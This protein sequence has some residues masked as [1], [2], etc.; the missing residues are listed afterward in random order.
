MKR[1]VPGS[2]RSGQTSHR[3]SAPARRNFEAALADIAPALIAPISS[4]E[5]VADVI[6]EAARSLVGCPMGFVAS[7]DTT[8]GA[9]VAHTL[10][11]R[12]TDC[13]LSGHDGGIA[14]RPDAEGRF[15]GLLGLALNQGKGFFTNA[16]ATH[17]A[18]VGLPAGHQPL[19]NLLAVPA[20][21]A[22]RAAGLI[23]LANHPEGFSEDDVTLV[24]RLARTYGLTLRRMQLDEAIRRSER[25]FRAL[26]EGS[27]DVML[28]LDGEGRA[29]YL[30]PAVRRVLGY[31]PEKLL[32]RPLLD[33]V[34]GEGATSLRRDIEFVMAGRP[35]DGARYRMR[36]ADGSFVDVELNAAPI[37]EGGRVVYVNGVLRDISERLRIEEQMRHMQKMEAIGTLAG[38]VAHDFNNLLTAIIGYASD[39]KDEAPP[40]DMVYEAA[41]VIEDAGRQ[42]AELTG[43]LLGFARKGKVRDEAVDVHA[44]ISD[45]TRVI[46]R[47]IDPRITITEYFTAAN[48][49]VRGDPGQLQQ[50]F[51][52]LCVNAR[53]AMPEGGALKIS[54]RSLSLSDRQPR[55]GVELPPGDYIEVQVRDNGCGIQEEIR[56][57]IFDPFF[58]T[59]KEGK[60][61]GMGLSMVYGIVASHDGAVRVESTE[62]HGATFTVLL[63]ADPTSVAEE[64]VDDEDTV[65]LR[66]GGVLVVDDE[67]LVRRLA[68]KI[69]ESTGYRVE[70]AEDGQAALDI[71]QRHRDEI[72]LVILDLVM[73]RMNGAECYQ[74]LKRLN[75]NI[76]VLLASGY[77][78]NTDVGGLLSSG[79]VGFVQKPYDRRSLTEVVDKVLR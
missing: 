7:I 34:P 47:T 39:L 62:G 67:P 45:V 16:P 13:P 20:L 6:L 63:P 26:A 32:G 25:S 51:L 77:R 10:A 76:R 30:S 2:P 46:G 56:S 31:A 23:I 40:G 57:R 8:T 3:A 12:V 42:A 53:D 19:N 5:T 59:K 54:T 74:Q 79:A 11:P 9:C 37:A 61:T 60:G 35:V 78:L 36:R 15:P 27:I 41:S 43:Q 28:R 75:P 69:L 4:I 1:D 50:V 52:N 48:H 29:L 18:A 72:D 58:T 71:Y 70:L 14:F 66:S 49:V 21:V 64:R 33:L 68:R 55:E 22:G 65:P 24:D 73:P 38:G 17:P 44:V